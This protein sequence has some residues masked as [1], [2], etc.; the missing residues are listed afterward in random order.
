MTEHAC[1]TG[2]F[3][4]DYLLGLNRVSQSRRRLSCVVMT[5]M[6]SGLTKIENK[7]SQPLYIPSAGLSVVSVIS[8]S[9]LQCKTATP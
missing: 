5:I 1:I 7:H 8:D 2:W 9:K 6:E 3:R 4:A